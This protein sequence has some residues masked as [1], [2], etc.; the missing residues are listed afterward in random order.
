MDSSSTF[1]RISRQEEPGRLQSRVTRGHDW[2]DWSVKRTH[3][4]SSPINL[5]LVATSSALIYSL[6]HHD[7]FHRLLPHVA[8]PPGSMYLCCLE[9]PPS[10][11]PQAEPGCLLLILLLFGLTPLVPPLLSAP[12]QELLESWLCLLLNISEKSRFP[13]LVV[14]DCW[15]CPTQARLICLNSAMSL[16]QSV[17]NC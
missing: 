10:S 13:L 9:I 8:Q 16:L 3:Q 15:P 17:L 5:K 6:T 11:I 7:L 12:H 2:S 14:P 1:L 4:P